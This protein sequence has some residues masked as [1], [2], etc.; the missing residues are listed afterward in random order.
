VYPPPGECGRP[1]CVRKDKQTMLRPPP[2]RLDLRHDDMKELAAAR[3][4][5]RAEARAAAAAA[6]AA[7]GGAAAAG[8]ASFLPPGV[9]SPDPK[10]SVAA[11]IGLGGGR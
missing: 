8:A 6:A 4:R 7:A 10:A 11:R 2:T 1:R 3:A 9:L 5:A